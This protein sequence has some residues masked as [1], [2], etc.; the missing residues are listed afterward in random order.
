MIKS[1]LLLLLCVAGLALATPAV[2]NVLHTKERPDPRHWDDVSDTSKFFLD[3]F[4]SKP[5]KFR[6]SLK[7]PNMEK[8]KQIALDVSDPKSPQYG[9]YLKQSEI[10]ELTKPDAKDVDVVRNFITTSSSNK[11]SVTATKEVLDVVCE[12]AHVVQTM[13]KT[14]FHVLQNRNKRTQNLL[15][16][17]DFYLPNDVNNKVQGIFGLHGLPLPPRKEKGAPSQPASVTPS[18]IEQVYNIKDAKAS[19]SLK[20]RQAVAEFQ[21]QTMNDAD[22]TEFF[23]NY[24]PNAASGD[25]KVYK[26]VG[27]PGEGGPG[28][29]ASLDIQYIMG[30]APGVK[31]EF[32]YFASNDFCGDLKNWTGMLLASDDVPLVT[33]VSYGWQGSLSQIGCQEADV[34][35]VDN[36]FAKLA[37][38]GIT[39]I[40]ASGDSGSGYAPPTPQCSPST[41]K[42][43]IAYSGEVLQEIHG[44]Q[45][46]FT[47]CFEAKNN[48][49]TF[50]EGTKP[51]GNKYCDASNFKNDTVLTGEVSYNIPNYISPAQCCD[52]AKQFNSQLPPNM[53]IQGWSFAPAKT[54]G[55]MDCTMYRSITGTSSKKGATSVHGQPPMLNTTCTS[56]KSVSST[57]KEEGSTSFTPGASPKNTPLYPSWPASSPWVTAVGSTRFVD[58]KVGNE[59]MSTDQ[60]GSGGGFSSMFGAFK[61]QEDD[62]AH[63]FKVAPQLPPAGMFNKTGRATPDVAALGEGFQVITG[64]HTQPVGG[65]SASAPTFA[66]VISLLNEARLSNGKPALGY[67]NPWLYGNPAMLTDIVKG[68]NA[69]GRGQFDLPYGFNCT[70]GYDPVSGLGTPDFEKMLES[71]MKL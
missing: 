68:N 61:D 63:Y 62:I 20:N 42:K 45:S 7:Q 12:N 5:F 70:K 65:T 21:G 43:G 15:R 39:I 26:F 22:L 52:F 9:Q 59:E 16:A 17:K 36:D 46:A 1:F 58:Q 67:L 64:G 47:C 40:F 32:W 19:G 49:W 33:S 38:K 60:F 8:V 51:S 13:L 71:A 54:S 34:T 57:K 41:G 55:K 48:P 3:A 4:L 11:C 53:R 25:D 18:V 37:A 56:F 14:S 23:K 44:V 31:T 27:D 2:S 35:A 30:V 24:V 6:M 28:V 29:E 66:A 50:S 69:I 10:D